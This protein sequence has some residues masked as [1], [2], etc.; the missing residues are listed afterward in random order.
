ME[1]TGNVTS[2]PCFAEDPELPIVDTT[3]AGDCFSAGFITK[4][5]YHKPIKECLI[6]GSAA[7][8]L[9]ITKKGCLPSNPT[10]EQ[11]EHYLSTHSIQS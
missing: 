2:C 1:N 3:G 10:K 9:C 6:Y 7:A 11:V 4:Y 8:Y 5:I